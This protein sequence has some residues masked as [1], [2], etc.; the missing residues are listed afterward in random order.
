MATESFFSSASLALLASAG[1]GKDGKAYSIKPADGTGDFTFSRGADFVATRIGADGLIEKGRENLLVHSNGFTTSPWSNYLIANP[2]S[3]Q[4]GYDG[5]NNAWLVEANSTSNFAGVRQPKSTNGI[6]VLSVYAKA[7]TT[8][9]LGFYSSAGFGAFELTGSG[10]VG[11]IYGTGISGFI[12]LISN[13][14]YRCSIV[15]NGNVSTAFIGPRSSINSFNADIGDNI[16]IQNAQLEI[17]I[18][19]T[20]V[21]ETGATT[22]KVGVLEDEPRFDYSGGAT[23][24]SLLLEPS[25]TNLVQSEYFGGWSLTPSG[26]SSIEPNYA[27]S[28]EGVENAYKVNFVV[29]GDSDLALVYSHSVTGGSTYAYSIYIKG[30][31]SDIGKDI[32]VK[33]KRSGG[34]SAGTTTFQTLTGE[35]QRIDFTTTYAAN[36]AT[37]NFYI[38]SNDATSCLIYG[39]QAEEGSYPTSYIPNH[40]GGS[41]TRGAD[42]CKGAVN[43]SNFNDSEG[44]LYAEI[45]TLANDGTFRNI[46]ISNGTTAQAIRI[47]YRNNAD[48][49]TFLLGSSSGSS[50]TAS[51]PS[52]TDFIKVAAKYDTDTI[53]LFI[54]GVL[55]NTLGSLTMPTGLQQ[56][57]FNIAGVLP[58][59]GNAKQVLYFPEAL[60]DEDCIAL[61]TL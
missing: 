35:W 61:T 3:G 53:K 18:A 56:L 36:N 10:G 42:D 20:D 29:Q 52:A 11:T 34:D 58:L 6:N 19:A 32:V 16:Y 14:W 51:I 15:L 28:P 23:C 8:D 26:I 13:G 54:N 25:R 60:P 12:E 44:V 48:Q 50:I 33:S 24:P 57:D 22:E 45:S 43:A 31:G 47:Y 55:T 1:A 21:I 9:Y 39:A 40:S 38:S 5:T 27:I 30:E 37:A 59:Y 4:T 46:S 49:I 41:V 17:G 7:G 2:I